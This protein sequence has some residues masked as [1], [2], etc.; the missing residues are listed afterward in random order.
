MLKTWKKNKGPVQHYAEIDETTV[1]V[2]ETLGS[3]VTEAGGSCN[4]AEFLDGYYAELILAIFGNSVYEEMK[5]FVLHR[6]K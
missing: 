2:W 4:Y 1:Y 5:N 3:P 6:L